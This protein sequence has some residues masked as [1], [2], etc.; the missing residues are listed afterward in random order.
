VQAVGQAEV[1]DDPPP[2]AV[3]ALQAKYEQYRELPPA[4]PFVVLRPEHIATWKA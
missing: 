4:G 2:G 3:E 1:V